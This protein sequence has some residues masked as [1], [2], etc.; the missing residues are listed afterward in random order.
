MEGWSMNMRPD[1]QHTDGG[2]FDGVVEDMLLDRYLH[3][4]RRG[5]PEIPMKEE[6]TIK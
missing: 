2:I 3:V 4:P 6:T 5:T 1:P